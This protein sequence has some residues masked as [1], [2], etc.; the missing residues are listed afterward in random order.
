MLNIQRGISR[1]AVAGEA[2]HVNYYDE[3]AR[4]PALTRAK[5][6]SSN[7]GAGGLLIT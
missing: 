6:V 4:C 3:L 5:G 1:R 7:E 2:S